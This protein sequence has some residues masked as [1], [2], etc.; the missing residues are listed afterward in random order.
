MPASPAAAR[1]SSGRPTT[2]THEPAREEAEAR[3]RARLVAPVADH[4]D[5]TP[6]G[7][8]AVGQEGLQRLGDGKGALTGQRDRAGPVGDLSQLGGDDHPTSIEHPFAL[9]QQVLPFPPSP[10]GGSPAPA[11]WTR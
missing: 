4:G 9:P 2:T 10:K 5:R 11:G 7:Q 8:G 6:P 3:F 1:P